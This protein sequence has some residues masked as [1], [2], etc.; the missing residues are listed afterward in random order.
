[1]EINCPYCHAPQ[2]IE[3][4][5]IGNNCACGECGKNYKVFIAVTTDGAKPIKS[6]EFSR[7]IIRGQDGEA[8]AY[9][10]D[11]AFGMTTYE[12]KYSATILGYT[13]MS[14]KN[15]ANVSFEVY[16]FSEYYDEGTGDVID[17]SQLITTCADGHSAIKFLAERHNAALPDNFNNQ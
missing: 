16:D 12:D 13:K 2:D 1:M 9:K 11:V 5:A 4:Q 3:I 14:F 10:K 7:Y 17:N 6:M 15:T 8:V